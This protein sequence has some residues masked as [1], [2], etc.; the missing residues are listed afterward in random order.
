MSEQLKIVLRP[1]G[2]LDEWTGDLQ[3]ALWPLAAECGLDL[4]ESPRT[5]RGTAEQWGELNRRISRLVN[6]SYGLREAIG[7]MKTLGHLTDDQSDGP[8]PR[9]SSAPGRPG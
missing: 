3:L 8:P 5:F 6:A 4:F 1:V 9:R 2:E 7:A